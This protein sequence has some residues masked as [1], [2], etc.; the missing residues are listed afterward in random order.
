MTLH[1]AGWNFTIHEHED[2]M[3]VIDVMIPDFVQAKASALQ[4]YKP[5]SAVADFRPL[6]EEELKGALPVGSFRKWISLNELRQ[7]ASESEFSDLWTRVEMVNF[8][9]K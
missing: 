2:T 9:P 4:Q 7:K 3:H 1:L 5:G 6:S 8:G